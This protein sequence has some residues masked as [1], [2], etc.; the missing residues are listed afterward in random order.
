MCHCGAARATREG[1]QGEEQAAG[2]TT[3]AVFLHGTQASA[4]RT[5][6]V[7]ELRGARHIMSG[8]SS[9]GG[10]KGTGPRAARDARGVKAGLTP[11]NL[12]SDGWLVITGKW[13]AFCTAAQYF[14]CEPWEGPGWRKGGNKGCGGQ[15]CW[16]YPIKA[17]RPLITD[18]HLKSN[19]IT[20]FSTLF[21]SDQ[22]LLTS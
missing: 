6:T 3:A 10:V 4:S 18:Y 12:G 1:G 20:H 22:L 5:A 7:E 13:S 21:R 11:S 14:N 17:I 9:R 15:S 19:P 2:A 8:V 16:D